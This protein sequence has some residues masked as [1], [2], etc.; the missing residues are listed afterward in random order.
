[1][2]ARRV[3]LS[4]QW[5][6]G[7]KVPRHRDQ[8]LDHL[9]GLD[10]AIVMFRERRQRAVA[11]FLFLHDVRAAVRADFVPEQKAISW[12]NSAASSS[13]PQSEDAFVTDAI[14]SGKRFLPSSRPRMWFAAGASSGSG[15]FSKAE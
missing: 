10:G 15:F 4:R 9:R 2:L 8:L 13:V 12:R 3:A 5:E 7:M 1:M 11:V 6:L 14:T